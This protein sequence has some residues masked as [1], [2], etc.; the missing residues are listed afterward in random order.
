MRIGNLSI[1]RVFRASTIA[2]A[3]LALFG[4]LGAATYGRFDPRVPFWWAHCKWVFGETLVVAGHT[5]LFQLDTAY[6]WTEYEPATDY[7]V[8]ERIKGSDDVPW[9]RHIEYVPPALL[10]YRQG[11]LREALDAAPKDTQPVP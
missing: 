11:Q 8:K 9:P 4:V 7:C 5:E 6:I 3:T 10:S 1:S 2:A